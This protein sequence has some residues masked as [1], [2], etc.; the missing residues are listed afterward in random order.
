MGKS[1]DLN[2]Y[3]KP[4]VPQNAAAAIPVAPA[5]KPATNAPSMPLRVGQLYAEPGTVGAPGQGLHELASLIQQ[6]SSVAI[7]PNLPADFKPKLAET[8]DIADLDEVEQQRIMAGV[9]EVRQMHGQTV[10]DITGVLQQRASARKAPATVP[11]LAP[12]AAAAPYVA[13]PSIGSQAIPGYKPIGQPEYQPSVPRPPEQYAAGWQPPAPSQQ[14]TADDAVIDLDTRPAPPPMQAQTPVQVPVP[15]AVPPAS[16]FAN[17]EQLSPECPH[18][19]WDRNVP[20]IA[21]PTVGEKQGFVHSVLGQ[22][23]F[24]QEYVLLG[25]KLRLR[26]RT[27]TVK[28][29]DAIY[30]QV[31]TEV[32]RGEVAQVDYFEQVN[33]YRLFLQMTKLDGGEGAVKDLPDGLSPYTNPGAEGFWDAEGKGPI[34][35]SLLPT[36][37]EYV[38][39]EVLKTETLVRIA[40]NTC[41]RFN[42]LV[43]KLEALVDNSDFWK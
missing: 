33:R 27:L 35:D 43:A 39:S 38:Q 22:K 21:E 9:A 37:S 32:S 16:T 42:R 11:T 6:E 7:A 20:D 15:A 25:G 12:P 14:F 17:L 40:Q 28:E 8:V 41:S 30:S 5:A 13:S 31:Q 3:G 19:G 18:C 34:G 36:V 10:P 2:G 29:C 24:T 1:I 4:P 23:A 26:F